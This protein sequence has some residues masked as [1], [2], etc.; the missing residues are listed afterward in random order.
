MPLTRRRPPRLPQRPKRA[1]AV[2]SLSAAI[3]AQFCENA[4]TA[5]VGLVGGRIL[6]DRL[7]L[8]VVKTVGSK[9]P[10]QAPRSPGLRCTTGVAGTRSGAADVPT[11]RQNRRGCASARSQD[12][13]VKVLLAGM[14]VGVVAVTVRCDP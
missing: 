9:R 11:C 1:A 4:Q 12:R 6:D 2:D 13:N 3:G 7:S 14:R 8:G 10:A 5:H